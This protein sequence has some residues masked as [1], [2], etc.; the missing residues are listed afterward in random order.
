MAAVPF[1]V[2]TRE[3]GGDDP[4]IASD[5]NNTDLNYSFSPSKTCVQ[6]SFR[7]ICATC[8]FA[9]FVNDT[10]VFFAASLQLE[11]S[12]AEEESLSLSDQL[13]RLFG[14]RKIPLPKVATALLRGGKQYYL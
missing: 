1:F 14:W 8:P 5:I 13:K 12:F 10:A 2:N 6:T 11:K 4:N 3:F 9:T 7:P